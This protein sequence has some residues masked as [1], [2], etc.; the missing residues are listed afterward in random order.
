MSPHPTQ[1]NQPKIIRTQVSHFS[2]TSLNFLSSLIIWI[3]V[4]QVPEYQFNY[5]SY[6]V[7]YILP[8]YYC[9]PLLPHL[10]LVRLIITS[11]DSLFSVSPSLLPLNLH[12]ASPHEVVSQERFIDIIRDL[13]RH[14]EPPQKTP[15]F[16]FE[17]SRDAALHNAIVLESF[18]FDIDKSIR[19]QAGSQIFYGS[20]FKDPSLLH[21]LLEHHPH[22]NHYIDY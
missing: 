22:W 17:R 11:L 7:L 16:I 13:H 12:T 2:L 5:T 6:Y 3:L 4:Y 1:P 10:Y 8:T 19:A 21:E 14:K 18:N 15:L 20:E 9:N